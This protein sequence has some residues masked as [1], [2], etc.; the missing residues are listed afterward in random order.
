MSDHLLQARAIEGGYRRRTVLR[1]VDLELDRGEIVVLLGPNG[2]G[3]TTL[4]KIFVGLLDQSAGTV[5]GPTGRAIG[6]V[7]QG[8]ATYARLTVRENLELFARLMKLPQPPREAAD[9]T[10]RAGDLEPWADTPVSDLS[11]GLRQRLNIA[12]GLL[13]DPQLLVLDEPTT[14]VDLVHR[15]AMFRMLRDRADAGCSVLYSTHSLE[16]ASVADRIVVIVGGRVVYNGS[17]EG[18]ADAAT[19]FRTD[20]HPYA[21]VPGLDPISTGLLAIWQE[22]VPES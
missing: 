6:W 12:V 20:K 11:G 4:M 8:G 7:P 10:I 15:T 1:G 22:G 3:K 21:H 5:E 18:L 13:G 14:G 16:D 17:L 19:G 2:A 9:A